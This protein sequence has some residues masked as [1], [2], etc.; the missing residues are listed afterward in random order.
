MY[1]D[2]ETS[3]EKSKKIRYPNIHLKNNRQ[4][5]TCGI[6]KTSEITDSSKI[7]FEN[8]KS[9]AAHKIIIKQA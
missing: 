8:R 3:V 1:E 9:T 7:S 4:R 5:S 6:G 2:K